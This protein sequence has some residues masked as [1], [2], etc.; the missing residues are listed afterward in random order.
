[1]TIKIFSLAALLA[2][3]GCATCQQ[4]PIACSVGSAVIVGSAA[5]MIAAHRSTVPPTAGTTGTGAPGF[6]P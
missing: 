6:H 4:H 1:M 5:A 2:L 3:S